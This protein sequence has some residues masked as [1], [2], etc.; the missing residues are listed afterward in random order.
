MAFLICFTPVVTD[1]QK[2]ANALRWCIVEMDRRFR[3]MAELQVRNIAGYN[4]KVIAGYGCREAN[5]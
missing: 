1:M 5:S 2:A 3:L 4:R